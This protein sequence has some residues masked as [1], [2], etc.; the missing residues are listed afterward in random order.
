[1]SHVIENSDAKVNL[2]F[3]SVGLCTFILSHEQSLWE[4]RRTV[5][6]SAHF[7][8]M[9]SSLVNNRCGVLEMIARWY[10]NAANFYFMSPSESTLVHPSILLQ[11]TIC[12][13]ARECT[14]SFVCINILSNIDRLIY[15]FFNILYSYKP[16]Q[17]FHQ[18]LSSRT[19]AEAIITT[20]SSLTIHDCNINQ[21]VHT[22]MHS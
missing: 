21:T 9:S 6:G 15:N 2:F 13:F 16:I 11:Y 8:L 7:Q 5:C 17:P 20:D 12:K 10:R 1:M 18:P 4:L 14:F 19:Q 22:Q 3:I